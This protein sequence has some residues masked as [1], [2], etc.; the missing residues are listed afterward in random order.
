MN[1]VTLSIFYDLIITKING[2]G[3]IWTLIILLKQREEHQWVTKLSEGNSEVNNL[4][5][6]LLLFI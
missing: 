3:R 5:N 2:G 4:T 6:I 1:E